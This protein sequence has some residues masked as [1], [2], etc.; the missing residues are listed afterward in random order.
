MWCK[1]SASIFVHKSSA[2]LFSSHS[3]V[4][5]SSSFSSLLSC[6]FVSVISW[7][8]FTHILYCCCHIP[9][10]INKV[11]LSTS[12]YKLM[13]IF[14]SS[15]IRLHFFFSSSSSFFFHLL[16]ST[17]HV[18]IV[19]FIYTLCRHQTK[20]KRWMFRQSSSK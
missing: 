9:S 7:H 15:F 10:T 8:P 6:D 3:V 14:S 5:R 2:S 4:F 18:H 12:R 19:S 20:A 11:N 16:I 13:I 1:L 17:K